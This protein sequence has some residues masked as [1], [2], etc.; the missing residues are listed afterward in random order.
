V[1]EEGKNHR[2]QRRFSSSSAFSYWL[3]LG[4]G[5]SP[6]PPPGILDSWDVSDFPSP[7]LLHQ[8]LR[9]CLAREFSVAPID[10]PW[11]FPRILGWVQKFSPL[12]FISSCLG[13]KPF[14]RPPP[15]PKGPRI[16]TFSYAIIQGTLKITL[17]D[18]AQPLSW[19]RVLVNARRNNKHF[20]DPN[21]TATCSLN[22]WI[23]C[24]FSVLRALQAGGQ[25]T[26]QKAGRRWFDSRQN[27]FNPHASVQWAQ[28]LLCKK[29]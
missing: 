3:H 7:W 10:L 5:P 1:S 20:P 13:F 16:P 21:S 18:L 8:I 27:H 9:L 19:R 26:V 29:N 17:S 25:C 4:L 11:S 23:L 14:Y 22:N 12:E 6:V 2:R 15:P 24:M 28:R